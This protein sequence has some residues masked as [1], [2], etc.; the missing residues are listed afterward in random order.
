MR[1]EPHKQLASDDSVSTG[2]AHEEV[3]PNTPLQ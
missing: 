3:H 2:I 1:V